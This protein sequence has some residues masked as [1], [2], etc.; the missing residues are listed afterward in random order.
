MHAWKGATVIRRSDDDGVELDNSVGVYGV[1]ILPVSQQF[2]LFGRV[3]YHNS[4]SNV[5]EEDGVAFGGGAQFNVN[6]RFGVRAEYT[7]LEGD[8]DAVDT[9]GAS[10]V[11][12][13][14]R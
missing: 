14:G 2:D 12:K 6:E 11:F 8:D 9:F 10:A 13:F 4:E 1:G 7:R 5:A 3:G